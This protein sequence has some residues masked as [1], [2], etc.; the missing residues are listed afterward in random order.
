[1]DKENW[2]GIAICSGFL[3]AGGYGIGYVNATKAT[4]KEAQQA[5][6][7]QGAARWTSNRESGEAEFT[8]IQCLKPEVK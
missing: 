1:M 8:F 2:I 5:A 3:F 4:V 6:V 7:K